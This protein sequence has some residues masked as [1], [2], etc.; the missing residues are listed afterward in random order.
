MTVDEMFN[1]I[2]NMNVIAIPIKKIAKSIPLK[3]PNI[4][5]P[6]FAFA[7]IK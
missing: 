2:I 3:Y 6:R 7:G 4:N 5:F 1:V